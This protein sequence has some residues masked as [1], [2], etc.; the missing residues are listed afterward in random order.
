MSVSS[1]ISR[2][3]PSK[4]TSRFFHGRRVSNVS[5]TLL[6]VTPTLNFAGASLPR[7][8]F[9]DGSRLHP[10]WMPWRQLLPSSLQRTTLHPFIVRETHARALFIN[11]S[12]PITKPSRLCGMSDSSASTG[13]GEA[14][15]IAPWPPTKTAVCSNPVSLASGARA[16]NSSSSSLS[17]A[18]VGDSVRLVA[19]SE[20]R[21]SPS[22]SNTR[23]S[24]MCLTLN[25]CSRSQKC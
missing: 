24:R 9:D 2:K 3:A 6:P 11:S 5:L 13:F 21:S 12:T 10:L 15:G 8:V 7:Q 1:S 20:R 4:R 25:G 17:H 18:G 14:T 16:A 23:F 19:R 22:C